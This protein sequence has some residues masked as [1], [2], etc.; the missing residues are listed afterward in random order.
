MTTRWTDPLTDPLTDPSTDPSTDHLAEPSAGSWAD[1]LADA[2]LG[3]ALE[4]NPGLAAPLQATLH[5]CVAQ[6]ERERGAGHVCLALGVADA[7]RLRASGLVEDAPTRAQGRPL[8]I[9]ADKSPLTEQDGKPYSG[10]Y[11]NASIE[12]WA[13]DNNYGKRVNASLSG[14]QFFR[15]GDAFAGGRAADV[16][17]FDDVTAGAGCRSAWAHRV[18]ACCVRVAQ[19]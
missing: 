3:W 7:A 13:Q 6:L 10:C 5:R 18:R 19:A 17:D 11:V 12:L 14:V 1:A 8:V 2:L 9:D 15:D 16:D 4:L